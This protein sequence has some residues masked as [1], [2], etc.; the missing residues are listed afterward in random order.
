MTSSTGAQAAGVE[1]DRRADQRAHHVEHRGDGDR[2]RRVEVAGVLGARAGEVDGQPIAGDPDGDHAPACRRRAQSANRCSPSGSPAIA[3]PTGRPPGPGRA[4]CTRAPR[5]A[6]RSRHRVE[7]QPARRRGRLRSAPQVG[8]VVLGPPRRMRPGG[9]RGE[10]RVALE[11]ARRGRSAGAAA[12]RPP[13]RACVENGGIEPGV[14]AADVGVM[15]AARR[16]EPQHPGIVE[17]RRH[18]RDVRQVRAA[19]ARIVAGVHRPRA[20]APAPSASERAHRL[21]H[22]PEVHR[23][24][25]RVRDQPAARVEHRAREV[26][27]LADVGR[28]RGAPQHRPPS[29]RRST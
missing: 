17:H 21:A 25:R 7:H 24:V 13:R 20:A 5:A 23:N 1:R 26:E 12:P 14:I 19:R 6:P 27:P 28:H 15:A 22:R 3:R 29:A 8:E 10:D 2:A 18:H 4:P 9:E 16:E 11:R